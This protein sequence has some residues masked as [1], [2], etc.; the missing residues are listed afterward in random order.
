MSPKR[1]KAPKKAAKRQTQTHIAGTSGAGKKAFVA[2]VVKAHAE[3]GQ[4]IGV[5]DPHGELSSAA[6]QEKSTKE[7]S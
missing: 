3:S 2:S 1:K 6:S 5:L 4:P 7:K